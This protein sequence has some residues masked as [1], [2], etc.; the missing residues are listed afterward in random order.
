MNIDLTPELRESVARLIRT[1][2]SI[3][4]TMYMLFIGM[5]LEKTDSDSYRVQAT[6]SIR[7]VPNESRSWV[8]ID[9]TVDDGFTELPLMHIDGRTTNVVIGTLQA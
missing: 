4:D 7:K 2:L 8:K 1:E 9:M 3:P 5:S 6:M